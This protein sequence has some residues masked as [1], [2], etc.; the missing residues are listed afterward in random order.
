MSGVEARVAGGETVEARYEGDGTERWL[1]T[2]RRLLRETPDGVDTV[3]LDA[4]VGVGRTSGDRDTRLLVAGLGA[5][6]LAVVLPTVA[7]AA[8][9]AFFAVAPASALLALACPFALLLWYRSSTVFLELR[10]D[11]SV[12]GSWRLPESEEAKAFFEGL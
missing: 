5:L 10:L 3:G 11:A 12:T 2:D 6:T 1:R 4:V 8:N 9:V 7:A